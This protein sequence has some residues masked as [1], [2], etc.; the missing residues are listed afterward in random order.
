MIACIAEYLLIVLGGFKQHYLVW[1]VLMGLGVILSGIQIFR[2]KKSSR[3]KTHIG[4]VMSYLWGGWF[5]SFFILILFANLREDYAVILPL[6]LVMYG[7]GIFVSGG[8]VD[9]RPLVIGGLIA[10]IA[11]VVSFFQPHTIQLIIMTGVVIVSYIIPGHMLRNL[12][13][14]QQA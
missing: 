8:V 4:N 2:Q 11:A 5:V 6:S 3:T 12:S 14:K 13:K 7:L 9:F 10:W 1:P